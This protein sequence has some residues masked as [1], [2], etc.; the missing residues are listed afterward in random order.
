[1][2]K[3]T[4]K[5]YYLKGLDVHLHDEWGRPINVEFKGGLQ[6]DSTAKFST[7]DEKVQK[8]LEASRGFGRDFYLD[9]VKEDKPAVV[10]DAPAPVKEETAPVVEKPVIEEVKDIKRF[11]NLVEMRNYMAEIGFAD[12]Q[13]MNYMQARAAAAKEGYDFQ[14]QK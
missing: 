5:T 10:R 8:A 1:M 6:V 4:Y 12:V 7:N 11:H 3:K 9:S 2:A 13:N 14:I